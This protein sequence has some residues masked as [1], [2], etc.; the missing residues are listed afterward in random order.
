[1]KK[2]NS[3]PAS[4]LYELSVSSLSKTT[5]FKT[6]HRC[7]VKGAVSSITCRKV[8]KAFSFKAHVISTREAVCAIHQAKLAWSVKAAWHYNVLFPRSQIIQIDILSLSHTHTHTHAHTHT[9]KVY[10]CNTCRYHCLALHEC[11]RTLHGFHFQNTVIRQFT[12]LVCVKVLDKS[13][14][15]IRL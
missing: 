6:L 11:V 7:N 1:M 4:L 12:P 13:L 2:L 10:Y 3:S 9:Q 15:D 14:E 8:P 5:N